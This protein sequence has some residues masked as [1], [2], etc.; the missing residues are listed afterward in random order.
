M[1]IP[2]QQKAWAYLQE[3]DKKTYKSYSSIIANAV[4]EY[5]EKHKQLQK[6]ESEQEKENKEHQFL[7][8]IKSI[9][10]ME[11]KETIEEI[12][13]LSEP[14]IMQSSILNQI[15]NQVKEDDLHNKT[16]SIQINHEINDTALDFI[17]I[18]NRED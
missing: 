5:Y 8:Q 12:F 18:F 10:R 7:Q 13:I 15:K 16:E 3:M 2:I 4:V 6:P 1:D 14:H 11:I 17:E 9:I